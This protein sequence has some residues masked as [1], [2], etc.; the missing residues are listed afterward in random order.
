MPSIFKSLKEFLILPSVSTDLERGH[1]NRTNWIALLALT[2]Q[3]PVF[4][5][6]AWINET[7][8]TLAAGL[9]ALALAGPYIAHFGLTSQRQISIVMGITSMFMGGILVHIGQGLAQIEMHFYFFVALSLLVAYRNP[10]VIVTAAATAAILHVIL[11]LLFPVSFFANEAPLWLVGIHAAFLV[12]QTIA[13]SIVARHFYDITANL[14]NRVALRTSQVEV[15]NREIREL[16]DSVEQG[17]LRVDCMGSIGSK[18]SKAVHGLLGAIPQS[19]KFADLLSRHDQNTAEWFEIGLDDVFAG[20]LPLE[21]TLDQLPKQIKSDTR[22][23][24]LQ[25]APV[26]NCGELTHIVVVVSDITANVERE[27]LEMESREFLAIIDRI[28]ADQFVFLEFFAEAEALINK[29]RNRPS[30]V[31]EDIQRDLHT[32]KGNAAVFGLVRVSDACHAIE[33]HIVENNELP[34]SNLWTELFQAWASTRGNLR[35]L[36]A[37]TEVKVTLGDEEYSSVLLAILNNVPKSQLATRVAAWR[38]EPTRRRLEHLAEQIIS[39]GVKLGKGALHVEIEDN[40]L[41]I[42]PKHWSRFWSS[43]VH[44][45]RNSV[46]HGMETMDERK[47]KNKLELG[48]ITLSTSI[49]ANSYV[50]AVKDNGRGID[51]EC[52]RVAA[53]RRGLPCASEHDLMEALFH[54]GVSTSEL[55]TDTSGRGVGMAAVRE[56]CRSLEG[57]INIHTQLGVGT[58]FQFVFP[59]ESMAHEMHILL[60]KYGIEN[61]NAITCNAG[62]K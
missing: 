52:V 18:Y 23:M 32:L 21:L 12:V 10:L 28:A 54:V 37:D 39:L 5:L 47:R 36:M 22:Y 14:E 51:W 33:D 7:G 46:D 55:V 30:E 9:S 45:I 62:A 58:E 2:V 41:R 8:A 17:F 34:P 59:V 56:T 48:T 15:A 29:L 11:W 25:Y 35:R 42:D 3:L 20:I 40:G 4:V 24:S 44:V 49:E 19:N 38:L 13:I 6:I 26:F 27:K 50:I 61:P 16:L 43:I 60:T 57:T 1:L 31:N 53:K